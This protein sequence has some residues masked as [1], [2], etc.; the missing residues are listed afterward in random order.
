MSR[1]VIIVFVIPNFIEALVK[2][3]L[4]L[5]NFYSIPQNILRNTKNATIKKYEKKLQQVLFLM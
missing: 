1:K 4:F 5:S 2:A 3:K